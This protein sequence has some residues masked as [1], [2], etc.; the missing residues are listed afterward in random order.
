M[1]VLHLP[2]NIASQ[3]NT[4]VRILREMGIQA[5]GLVSDGSPIQDGNE[6]EAFNLSSRK[7][8]SIHRIRQG[9]SWYSAVLSAIRW[10]E[11]VHWHFDTR[12]LRKDLDLKYAALLNKVR[13]VEFH[14]SDIRIPEAASIDN[15]FFEKFLSQLNASY[16]ISYLRSRATQE[17]FARHGFECLVSNPELLA[18]LQSD[19]FPSPFKIELPITLSDFIPVYPDP[20]NPLPWVVHAPSHPEIKGTPGVLRTINQLK[21]RYPFEFKL[22]QGGPRQEALGMIRRCDI[23]LDQFVIG[24]FGAVALEA[25]SFGKPVLCYMKP[26]LMSQFPPD[27]PILNSNQDNL[28]DALGSLLADGLRQNELGHR[29][30]AYVEKHHDARRIGQELVTLYQRLIDRQNRGQL[31]HERIS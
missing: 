31:G 24:S 26:S 17:R 25:M 8:P 15:P 19:L 12:N 18:Y 30:R 11:V 21:T 20:P 13:I 5:R 29:S 10:A 14:G 7:R 27:L 1:K 23:F 3:I 28:A 22:I 2:T 6:I 9:L 16:P 4:K